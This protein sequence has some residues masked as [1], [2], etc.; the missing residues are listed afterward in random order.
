[1]EDAE[2]MKTFHKSSKFCFINM[3]FASFR[4]R[5]APLSL[6]PT[7]VSNFPQLL[8]RKSARSRTHPRVEDNE[9]FVTFA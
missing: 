9:A 7:R 6:L 5:Y 2:E 4:L 1:M 3:Q 8:A